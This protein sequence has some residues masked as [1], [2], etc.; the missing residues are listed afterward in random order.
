MRQIIHTVKNLAIEQEILS[1]KSEVYDVLL[2]DPEEYARMRIHMVTH[3]DARA[4]VD[5]LEKRTVGFQIETGYKR[6]L[7]D[8]EKKRADLDQWDRDHAGS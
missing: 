2:F 5:L 8:D 6:P 1:D 3:D 4:L 7:T